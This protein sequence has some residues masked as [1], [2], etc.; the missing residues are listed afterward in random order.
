MVWPF[1]ARYPCHSRKG[2][3]CKMAHSLKYLMGG[4]LLSLT[5][6]LNTLARPVNFDEY[7]FTRQAELVIQGKVLTCQSDGSYRVRV[8]R[9]LKGRYT[10]DVVE[11]PYRYFYTRLTPE[12]N[13]LPLSM[14][15]QAVFF[16]QYTRNG[17]H[18]AILSLTQRARQSRK[19]FS[20][21][22]S[23]LQ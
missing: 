4:V 9:V 12:W 16:L 2:R 3:P 21:Q 6:A 18:D 8:E 7:M 11:L 15:T 5:T 23:P 1:F 19:R 17:E 22:P 14:G 20:R 13:D 10:E